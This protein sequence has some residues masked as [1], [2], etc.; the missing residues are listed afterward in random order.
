MAYN[1]FTKYY[2]EII[3]WNG[4]SLS[5]EVDLILEFIEKYWNWEKTVLEFA[6]GTGVIARE[7]Q[8]KSFEVY[9]VDMSETM[10]RKAEKNMWKQNV[11]LWDMTSIDL[12]KKYDVVLCNYNS[13]CHLTSWE[14]WQDF[15]QNAQRHVNKGGILIFDINTVS[16]FESITQ[17]FA[18]FYNIWNDTVCLEMEKR[19]RLYHWIVKMFIK[20]D[21]WDY[22]LETEK[23]S[24]LSFEIEDIQS[25]LEKQWFSTLHLEDF[26]KWKV[27]ET[28]ERVYFIAKKN[29]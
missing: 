29:D 9:G 26:H 13:I 19:K 12:W 18:Q 17:D 8:K 15:F 23:I 24:E 21:S 6:C 16:E 7:L 14:S 11:T 2:D 22:T 28:S 5:D 25:E 20:N 10:L 1:F 3:R 27:D 4:Y